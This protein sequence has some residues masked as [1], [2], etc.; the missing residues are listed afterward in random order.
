MTTTICPTIVG[1]PHVPTDQEGRRLVRAV[2]LLACA[3]EDIEQAAGAASLERHAGMMFAISTGMAGGVGAI[4][5]LAGQAGCD[6][7]DVRHDDDGGFR[8]SLG[9]RL[10]WKILWH[11]GYRMWRPRNGGPACFVP[12]DGSN[13]CWFWIEDGRLHADRGNLPFTDE[14]DRLTGLKL[15]D[16]GIRRLVEGC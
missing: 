6:I 3:T 16:A 8:F 11:H 9:V 14:I 10:F 12:A 7:V 5:D 2:R 1:C 15:A 13:P 4:E